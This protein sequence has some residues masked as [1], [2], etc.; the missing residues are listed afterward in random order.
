M[1][2][3]EILARAQQAAEAADDLRTLD[4]VRV[5]YLGKKGELT[6]LLKGLGKLDASERP[7]AGAKIN[8]AKEA[9]QATLDLRK[10]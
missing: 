6:G 4:E 1:D 2:T 3:Q 7:A 5:A 10:N 8:E 9:L